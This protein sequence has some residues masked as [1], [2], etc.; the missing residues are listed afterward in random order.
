[1]Q[2]GSGVAGEWQ[3]GDAWVQQLDSPSEELQIETNPRKQIR[4]VQ[5]HCID[6]AINFR[7]F[8]GV[9]MTLWNADNEDI[10]LQP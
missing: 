7:V 9:I 8:I 4:F 6:M 1:V 3:N 5:Y 2:V 10:G